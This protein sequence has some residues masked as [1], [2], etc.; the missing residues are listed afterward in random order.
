MAQPHPSLTSEQLMTFEN[1][2]KSEHKKV[3]TRLQELEE[4]EL[5]QL[6]RA[7]ERNDS[8]GD[9]AKRDQIRQRLVELI[10]A[11]RKRKGEIEAALM[12]IGNGTYGI[13]QKTGDPIRMERLVAVPTATYDI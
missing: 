11:E 4:Q 7:Q 2:L 6:A 10:E 8:Y 1:N 13:D 5:P 3:T 12:R 9:D